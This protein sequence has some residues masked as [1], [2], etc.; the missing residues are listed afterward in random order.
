[1][2]GQVVGV[3]EP[4]YLTFDIDAL[5]PAYAPGTVGTACLTSAIAYLN[6]S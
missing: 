5:D 3:E 6:A 2:R 1:M 4:C